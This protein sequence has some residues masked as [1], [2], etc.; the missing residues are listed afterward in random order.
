M[1]D[2]MTFITGGNKGLGYE[3]ARRPKEAG[4]TVYIGARDEQRGREAAEDLGVEF[5][6]LDVTDE[7]SV[8][9]ASAE[10]DRREG[11]PDVLVNNAGIPGPRKEVA[12]ITGPD[13]ARVLDANVVGIVR[14]THA[15][16][17]LLQRT[18]APVIVNVS[19]GLGSFATNQ[20]ESRVKSKVGAPL[21][22]ASKAALNML[23]I[24]YAKLLPGVKIN[25]PDPGYTPTDFND[26]TG[27]QTVAEGTDAVFELAIT[28]PDGH[29]GTFVD[30]RGTAAW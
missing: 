13:V 6:R 24:E 4:Q 2:K 28:G 8:A 17:P 3:T 18:E 21:Y 22:S 19:G 11:R 5:V 14:V 16:L 26:N 12:D 25:V 15:F 30:R 29:T 9:E 20:D 7:G 27:I 1:P 10:L 23:T